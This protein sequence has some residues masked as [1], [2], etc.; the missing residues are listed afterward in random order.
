MV[1]F[2][3]RWLSDAVRLSM[4]IAVAV[5]AM[6]VPALAHDYAAALLQV[7]QDGRRDIDQREASARQFYRLAGDTDEALIAALR[8]LEPSNAETLAVSV[9]RTRT[10]HAAYDHIQAAPPLLRPMVAVADAATDAKGYERAVLRTALSIF[11][12]EVVISTASAVYGLAGLVAGSF[13]A[14]VLISLCGSFARPRSAKG[15]TMDPRSKPRAVRG[16]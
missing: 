16:A 13:A 12:P 4:S 14:H 11:A 15:G 2:I 10:L 7:A 5:A 6:Q 8:P 9:D 3:A 1:A